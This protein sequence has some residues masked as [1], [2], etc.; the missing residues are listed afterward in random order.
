MSQSHRSH[1][2][3]KDHKFIRVTSI[4]RVTR[5]TLTACLTCSLMTAALAASVLALPTSLSWLWMF[6][7]TADWRPHSSS[8]SLAS[9]PATRDVRPD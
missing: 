9:S 4:T 2:C 3:H 6:C 5:V 1:K 8:L 7:L